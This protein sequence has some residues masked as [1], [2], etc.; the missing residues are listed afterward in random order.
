[1]ERL[2]LQNKDI[3]KRM[4]DYIKYDFETDRRTMKMFYTNEKE[5]EAYVYLPH[6]DIFDIIVPYIDPPD[7][8]YGYQTVTFSYEKIFNNN[9]LEKFTKIIS[10]AYECLY[11][12]DRCYNI[13]TI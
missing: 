7:C 6:H 12:E 11:I 9:D 10:S 2:T 8:L 1:M 4:F 13:K 3:I 5:N